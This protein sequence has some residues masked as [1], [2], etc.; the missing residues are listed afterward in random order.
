MSGETRSSVW[1]TVGVAASVVGLTIAQPLATT[2]VPL[3]L[4]AL[5]V[6]SQSPSTPDSGIGSFI[7]SKF[8]LDRPN[9]YVNFLTDPF[10]IWRA[11]AQNPGERTYSPDN[12][13]ASSSW[14][15]GAT[16]KLQETSW[17]PDGNLAT[18]GGAPWIR[19]PVPQ[20]IDP[21]TPPV[22]NI[23]E[24]DLFGNAQTYLLNPFAAANS[25]VAAIDQ[26]LTP[27]PQLPLTEGGALDCTAGGMS[28]TNDGGVV[29]VTYVDE[30]GNT[31]TA[32]VQTVDGVTYVSYDAPDGLPLVRPLR[33]L[34][35]P[36]NA[37]ADALEPAL[38]A[39][40]HYGY[41]DND[42]LANPGHH[43]GLLPKLS[44]TRTF[45]RDFVDGV[46]Q[47]AESLV[48]APTTSVDKVTASAAKPILN[49]VR[50][51]PRFTPADSTT[52]R[53][54]RPPKPVAISAKTALEKLTKAF[55]P[56]DDDEAAAPASS[57]GGAGSP[58]AAPSSQGE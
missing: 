13:L 47:G 22:A 28:C 8:P 30:D 2:A 12:V 37:L 42:P 56:K 48:N 9:V 6:E 10:G 27:N 14:G 46:R 34:G 49:D 40:V 25:F 4:A 36:G 52:G 17:A 53:H 32:R 23:H 45:V 7:N 55:A 33:E 31:I 11:L 15:G 38:T 57:Q 58:A 16:P 44:E 19:N 54:D 20:P 51:S 1:T 3:M 29:H 35:T 39:L 41:A 24:Y 43:L 5:I 21:A 26:R 50:E 18:G